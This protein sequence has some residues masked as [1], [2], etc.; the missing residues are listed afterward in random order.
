MSHVFDHHFPLF[1][2]L[3]SSPMP[4]SSGYPRE[5]RCGASSKSGCPRALPRGV[6]RYSLR[7]PSHENKRNTNDDDDDDD[8]VD[9]DGS[10]SNA[11]K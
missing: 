5:L 8:A 11:T 4:T 6:S 9:D 7:L 1:V 10:N 2:I 3:H